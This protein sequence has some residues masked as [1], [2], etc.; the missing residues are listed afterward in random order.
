[1][2]ENRLRRLFSRHGKLDISIFVTAIVFATIYVIGFDIFIQLTRTI[3]LENPQIYSRGLIV[4]ITI[5]RVLTAG[6]AAAVIV[7]VFYKNKTLNNISIIFALPIVILNIIFL[8]GNLVAIG[9]DYFYWSSFASIRF[10]IEQ[11]LFL[12]LCVLVLIKHNPRFRFNRKEILQAS[13]VFALIVVLFIPL[14]VFQLFFGQSTIEIGLFSRVHLWWLYSHF[15]LIFGFWFVLRNK[16]KD[17]KY[18]VCLFLS[19]AAFFHFYNGF[20]MYTVSILE[21]SVNNLPLHICNLAMIAIPIALITRWKALFYFTLFANSV[22]AMAASVFQD[23]NHYLISYYALKYIVQHVN[24]FFIPV[25]ILALGIF[26]MPKVK[27]FKNASIIFAV[28][29]LVAAIINVIWVNWYYDINFF[30]MM[31]DTLTSIFA[32]MITV[33]DITF[34]IMAFGYPITVPYL[35]FLIMFVGVVLMMMIQAWG[36]VYIHRFATNFEFYRQKR[37][38][39]SVDLLQL[40]KD[41]RGRNITE[42]LNEKGVDM[43]KITKFTKVYSG[44][45]KKAVDNLNLELHSGEVFGFLGHNGSGKTTTIKSMV[46]IL[47]ITDGNIEIFGYDIARQPLQAKRLIGYVPDNHAVYERLTGREYINYVANLYEVEPSLRQER[48]DKLVKQL[49]M[50]H[51]IDNKIKSYSH[52]MKQK[53][54]IIAALI[55]NPKLW[56]LDEP[57]TGLDP[58]SVFEVKQCMKDHAKAGNIV[59]FSSHILDVVEKICDRV[60]IIKRGQLVDLIDLKKDIKKGESLET[61]YLSKQGMTELVDEGGDKK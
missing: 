61:L 16:S 9:G 40:K 10:I 57:L 19:L 21:T 13:W 52:G 15:V 30:F 49:N 58:Q 8:R 4:W 31:D 47:P 17:L 26:E 32:F 1:M 29:F 23:V 56:I 59:F 37:I 20:Q 50:G 35:Y 27:D 14:W 54:T 45:D 25:L 42:P 38:E 44:Q 53:V 11:V 28:Y 60:C 18:L 43:I 5:L 2:K 12:A 39:Q 6:A 3:S 33:R 24:A 48:L 55:H 34:T 22:A 46:G 7:G 41:M 36:I 51:A